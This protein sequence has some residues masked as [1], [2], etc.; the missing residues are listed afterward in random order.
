MPAIPT[1]SLVRNGEIDA[2]QLAV[3]QAT[4]KSDP[5]APLKRTH[6]CTDEQEGRRQ[7][8]LS[9]AIIRPKPDRHQDYLQRPPA[10]P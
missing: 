6:P 9:E 4:A 1:L 3:E 5:P 8:F 10:Q 7:G 2:R